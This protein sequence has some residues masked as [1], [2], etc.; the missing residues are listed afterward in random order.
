M[1]VYQG[2]SVFG[3]IAIGRISVHKKDEQPSQQV[4]APAAAI[5]PQHFASLG[6]TVLAE[7]P[8]A[9]AHQQKHQQQD[10]DT[11]DH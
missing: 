5:P 2:K 1:E 7:K 9:P 10:H 8:D 4:T 11:V 6:Q 3:G